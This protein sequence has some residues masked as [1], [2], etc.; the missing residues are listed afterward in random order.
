LEPVAVAGQ[1]LEQPLPQK[2]WA[3]LVVLKWMGAEYLG[4]EAQL[5]FYLI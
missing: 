4:D 2:D 5:H 3:E 1:P